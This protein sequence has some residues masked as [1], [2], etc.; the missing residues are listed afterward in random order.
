MKY[1]FTLWITGICSLS[2]SAQQTQ[3]PVL[4][5]R[6]WMAITGKPLAATAGAM[7]F[8][9]G[10]NAVDASCAMLA[11]TCTMWDTLSWGGETQ[12]LIYN[13]KTRKVI[14]INAM[15]IAPT[16][17]TVAFFKNKGYDFPPEFGPLAATTPGTPGGLIYM[18]MNYGTM[19]LKQVLAPAME[20]ASGYPIEAQAANTIER[21]KNL[22]KEWPYS[23][24]IFLTHSGEKREAP[25]AGEIFVQ[26]DLLGTL[27]KIVAAEQQALQQGKTRKQALMAAY[28]RFYKGD[29]GQEFVRGCQEQGGLITMQDLEKWKPLEEEPLMVNYKGIDVYK[30]QQWT[31]GPVLLQ[32]LNILENFDLKAMGYNSTKYIHTLY[33]AM[34]LS[35]ADRDFYYGDP[36]AAPAE[37]VKGLLSKAYA[38]ERAGLIQFE[39][40]N[41]DIGPGDPYPYEGKVNP[42]RAL[43]KSRGFEQ[44]TGKRNFAPKHDMGLNLPDEA[45]MDRLWRGTTSIEAADKEGWVV[46]VTPSGGWLP[47]CIA[48]NTGIGMSQRM[49]SFV[50]DSTI[51]PFNVVAPG[52]RPRVT[53]SPSLALKDGKPFLSSAVQGGDTQDQNLL[54]FFLNVAEFGMNVQQA[55]EAANFN[56]NQLWLSLGG[57]RMDDRKPKAGQLLLNN[58]TGDAVRR[59]LSKM[60]YTLSFDDRTSGP[61]NAI[62]FDWKHGSLWGGSSNH[63]EDYGIAW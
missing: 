47:A 23:K 17:A 25:E 20:M 26:K 1:L 60:G 19:S 40:N 38:K 39:K 44:D 49:Q 4:H 63:G 7:I 24:K 35:F 9:Q 36:Y 6:N 54:Q 10:G 58:S 5:G 28:D 2:L 51:N 56:T 18:L 13:P 57:T 21:Q 42:Y 14:A 11:A 30:L 16:G 3:K 8:Q 50:L 32:A 46:S 22:I 29:I 52:K 12:V 61:V 34:N 45:Y 48:G 27:S 53:L 59:E 43:L 15:G 41:P 62:Y 31:Q 33:Q 37:P 55:A